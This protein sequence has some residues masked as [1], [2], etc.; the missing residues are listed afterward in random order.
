MKK[1][2]QSREL[3][4]RLQT[5]QRCEFVTC[6]KDVIERYRSFTS[7]PLPSLM[8]CAPK[9]E[10]I[11]PLCFVIYITEIRVIP[12]EGCAVAQGVQSHVHLEQTLKCKLLIH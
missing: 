8:S 4:Y 2:E 12:L 10:T 1:E 7:K 3:G 6:G 9:R 11:Q 5:Y